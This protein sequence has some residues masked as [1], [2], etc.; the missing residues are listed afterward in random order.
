MCHR[1]IAFNLGLSLFSLWRHRK[2]YKGRE[3]PVTHLKFVIEVLLYYQ[4]R[5]YPEDL[6]KHCWT[7]PNAFVY[8][9]LHRQSNAL[10]PASN[11][12]QSKQTNKQKQKKLSRIPPRLPIFSPRQTVQPNL[13]KWLTDVIERQEKDARYQLRDMELPN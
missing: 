9:R 4:K 10:F 13:L 12:S 5:I 11:S 1:Y 3:A 7:F 8:E 2:C 6:L